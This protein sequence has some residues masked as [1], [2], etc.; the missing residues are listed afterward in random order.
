MLTT[1][2][3]FFRWASR[4]SVSSCRACRGIFWKTLP[5][6]FTLQEQSR[7]IAQS[8][9]NF[10]F[11]GIMSF[12]PVSL[13]LTQHG[14]L[15]SLC[16]LLQSWALLDWSLEGQKPMFH[17]TSDTSHLFQSAGSAGWWWWMYDSWHDHEHQV[18][19]QRAIKLWHKKTFLNLLW[20]LGKVGQKRHCLSWVLRNSL[21]FHRLWAL[22]KICPHFPKNFPPLVDQIPDQSGVCHS[23]PQNS[24]SA[25]LAE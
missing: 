6:P 24:V 20:V 1:S 13:R 9:V 22:Y 17:E 14:S 2:A 11:H 5:I 12:S 16:C 19:N 21:P 7:H 25:V 3:E 10:V 18:G 23:G 15:C 8:V 4:T